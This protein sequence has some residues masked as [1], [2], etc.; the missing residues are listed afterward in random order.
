MPLVS[1]TRFRARAWWFVPMFAFHAQR[2]I[3]QIRNA[4]GC[5]ALALLKDRNRVFW[6]MTL[7][8]DERSMKAYM[9][10]GSHRKGYA[11]PGRLGGRGK[12]GSLVSG[13]LRAS[14]LDRS[15]APHAGRGTP[16]ETSSPR[17]TSRRFEFPSALDDIR[18]VV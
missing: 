17:P 2:S 5:M 11:S 7:W 18:H 15:R 10:S 4:N 1:I 6:T 13:P 3:A 12:H 9:T 8:E 14:G 16:F